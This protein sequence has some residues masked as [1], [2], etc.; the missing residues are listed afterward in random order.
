MSNIN[1][2]PENADAREVFSLRKTNPGMAFDL[3]QELIG[4]KPDDIWVKRAFAWTIYD[5]IKLSL[6]NK[7]HEKAAEYYAVFQ[8]LNIPDDKDGQLLYEKFDSVKMKIESESNNLPDDESM[9][10]EK[11][12]IE[13]LLSLIPKDLTKEISEKIARSFYKYLKAANEIKK[14]DIIFINKILKE[15]NGLLND[16]PSKLHSLTFYQITLLIKNDVKGLDIAVILNSWNPPADLTEDDFKENMLD[17]KRIMPFAE[18]FVYSFV[19]LLLQLNDKQKIASYLVQIDDMIIKYP[20]YSWLPYQKCKL[21]LASSND[22]DEILKSIIP[23]IRK[24]SSEF[25]TWS[26]LGEAL[27]SEPD[28][29]ISCYCKALTNKGTDTFLVKVRHNLAKLLIAKKMYKEAKYEISKILEIKTKE[30][31]KISSEIN[32]WI[33]LPWYNETSLIVNNNTFYHNNIKIAEDI[34]FGDSVKS[35]VGVITNVDKVSGKAYFSISKSITGG[36]KPKKQTLVKTGDVFE[37]KL[38]EKSESGQISYDV[39]SAEKSSKT[40]SKEVYREFEGTLKISKGGEI[41]FIDSVL[42]SKSMIESNKLKNNHPVKGIAIY[43][44]N[45]RYNEFGWKAIKVWRV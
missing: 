1:I 22:K 17:G 21:L 3:A 37:F 44:Q 34:V 41:G 5:Q 12:R 15:Y 40:P 24:K 28:K 4:K 8:N 26:I 10:T 31:Q 9:E 42:V 2:F 36:F 39:L 27:N 19:K 38:N 20:K 35:Y 29:A 43:S 13:S 16:K 18:K 14:Y 25:W 23:F 11:K 45:K 6:K 33:K 7:N 32:N 30:K